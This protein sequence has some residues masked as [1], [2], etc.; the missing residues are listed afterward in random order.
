M[1]I[2]RKD[3]DVVRMGAVGAIAPMVSEKNSFYTYEI[4]GSAL[5]FLMKTVFKKASRK[6]LA[7]TVLNY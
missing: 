6:R 7:P 5:T 3:R 1:G 2:I 4:L